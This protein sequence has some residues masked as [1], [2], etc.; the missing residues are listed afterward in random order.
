VRLRR[1]LAV[2]AGWTALTVGVAGCGSDLDETADSYAADTARTVS[3]YLRSE[4]VTAGQPA[5]V[6]LDAVHRWLLEPSADFTKAYTYPTL[7]VL[8]ADSR[9][10]EVAVYASAQGQVFEGSGSAR[11]V[12]CVR[13]VVDGA[14]TLQ[15]VSVECPAG[16]SRSPNP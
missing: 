1:T 7:T 6:Q 16:A 14:K 2:V 13:Y 11:G 10:V 5:A 15:A 9:R 3:E 12:A 4:V 8:A